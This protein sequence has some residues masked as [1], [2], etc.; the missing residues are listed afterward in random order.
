[1]TDRVQVRNT[2]R[3]TA[4]RR[5]RLGIAALVVA[6]LPLAALGPARAADQ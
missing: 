2:A 6:A 1:M 4:R 3:T 5:M